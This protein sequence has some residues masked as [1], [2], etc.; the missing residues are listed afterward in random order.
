[1]M[2]IGGDMSDTFYRYKMSHVV[3]IQEGK[4]QN[5][6]TIIKNFATICEELKRDPTDIEK[7]VS[8]R[9]NLRVKINKKE[10]VVHGNHSTTSLQNIINDYIRDYVLCKSCGNPETSIYNDKTINALTCSA[11]GSVSKINDGSKLTKYNEYLLKNYKPMNITITKS[12]KVAK[13]VKETIMEDPFV[14]LVRLTEH[15]SSSHDLHSEL[16]RIKISRDYTDDDIVQL[17]IKLYIY[18]KFSLVEVL[19]KFNYDRVI[20]FEHMF[21]NPC[22]IEQRKNDCNHFRGC[23]G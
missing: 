17:L 7:F 1:M 19:N 8:Y 2:N 21:K 3:T 11:C 5:T 16:L 23:S 20:I 15:S 12:K 18:K 13:V 4:N 22:R 9:L 6:K 10:L 14:L